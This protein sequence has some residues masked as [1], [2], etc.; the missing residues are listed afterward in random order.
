[1]R[2]DWY[3]LARAAQ[4]L[5]LIN[6]IWTSGIPLAEPAVA[7][8]VVQVTSGGF[9]SVHLDSLD[10]E[11]YRLLHTGN[12]GPKIQ[13]ILH[14][15]ENL[16]RCGKEPG[17]IIN[18]I[19]FT[20][21]LAGKDVERTIRYFSDKGIKTCL[22]QIC[23]AGLGSEH[24]E[25][26]PSGQQI[27]HAIGIR[28]RLNYP[29]SVLSM[30]TMDTNKFYCGGAVC[31]TVE[32]DVTPCSVI[33]QGFGNVHTTPFEEIIR[34]HC[35][36]LLFLPLRKRDESSRCSSCNNQPVCWGCRATAYYMTGDIMGKDPN[37]TVRN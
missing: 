24:S 35:R 33:R 3:M 11:I 14:G 25:W 20:R 27:R 4:D 9:V 6:N 34:S 21:P 7:D 36:E 15:V 28:D 22:T 17:E 12:P 16:L 10:A 37:C 32:G 19:T 2:K 5:G 26:V 18:C 13:A 8:Q 31:I 23:L 1:M 29:G 30:N